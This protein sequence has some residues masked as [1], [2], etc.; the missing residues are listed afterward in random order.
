[1]TKMDSGKRGTSATRAK[2]ATRRASTAVTTEH[3][4]RG[5]YGN[6]GYPFGRLQRPDF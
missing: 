3:S 2:R 4:T 1:M 6:D 5:E